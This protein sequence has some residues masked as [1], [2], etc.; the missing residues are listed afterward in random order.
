MSVSGDTARLCEN[1]SCTF[2]TRWIIFSFS[3][4]VQVSYGS[5]YVV[6]NVRMWF[7]KII[8]VINTPALT[9]LFVWLQPWWG[10]IWKLSSAHSLELTHTHT[11]SLSHTLSLAPTPFSH[12]QSLSLTQTYT[13]SL[14]HTNTLSHTLSLSHPSHTLSHTGTIL[15]FATRNH[16]RK[17]VECLSLSLISVHSA[18]ALWPTPC[19]TRPCVVLMSSC[20]GVYRRDR[21]VMRK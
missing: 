4:R 9:V 18:V 6:L 1:T 16:E 8:R 3:I 17:R 10:F 12:T 19:H 21:T 7:F 2:S 15:T 13:L 11:H 14:S 5:I 20:T